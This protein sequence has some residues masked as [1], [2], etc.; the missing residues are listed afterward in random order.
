M[1]SVVAARTESAPS[2]GYSPTVYDIDA[3]RRPPLIAA[4]SGLLAAAGALLIGEVLLSANEYFTGMEVYEQAMSDGVI[5]NYSTFAAVGVVLHLIMA[6]GGIVMGAALMVL[7]AFIF[8]GKRWARIVSWIVGVPVLLY[9]ALAMVG[10]LG[11]LIFSGSGGADPSELTRR[12]EQA[13]PFWLHAFDMVLVVLLAAALL[14]GLVCHTRPS[15]AA[16]FAPQDGG[17]A[18]RG[19]AVGS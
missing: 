17:V 4:S 10:L 13:W 5:P 18:D 1:V 7:A 16:Y 12:Y 15:V 8:V 6:A 14:T 3:P 2:R 19:Q 11:N 9:S